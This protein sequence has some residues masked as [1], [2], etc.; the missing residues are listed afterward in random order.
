M[1][2]FGVT[3]DLARKKL[4]P[5][6]YDLANRGLLPPGFSLVGFARRDWEHEDFAQITYEAVKEH[7][8]TPFRETVWQQLQE[9]VRF[10][11]GEF[12]DDAAFDQ[13][14]R[15]RPPAG[16]R[17]RHRRQLRVLP[18]HTAEVL[19]HRG[20]AAQA[21]RAV[22]PGPGRRRR[23]HAVAP[24]GDREAV[25]PR[26][27]DGARS[28]TPSSTRCS[29]P[30]RCSASTTTWAR[31]PS[32]TSWRCASP[33]PC[34]SRSGTASYVDHVQI[35]MSEDIGI[36]GRAGY[37]DGIGAARDV[38][39]NHLLQL[40]ALT[41]MEEP[42]SFDADSLR[43]EKE[44]IL[45]AVRLPADLALG[46][47][48]GQYSA[49]WQGGRQV[50]RLPGGGRHPRRLAD[51]DLRR[52]AA[53]RR[54]QALGGRPVL[55]AH[56]QAAHPADDGDRADLPAGAAP[57]VRRHR[58]QGT[59]QERPGHPRPAGRG[60]HRAVRLQGARLGDGGPRREHGL[61]LRRVV[62]R[63]LARGLRAA[64]PRRA[65]RRPAAVPA[66]GGG[67]A[68]LAHPRPD[69]AV[70]GREHQAGAVRVGLGPG[71]RPPTR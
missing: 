48:R 37:Y 43:Q 28:S 1:V 5:A 50:A 15:D 71:P 19:P 40:L 27:G 51:R 24:G 29:P 55:P 60:R 21:V 7:A 31:R 47:A 46:T 10:V 18:V 23:A 39:Q 36:G 42:V 38:I 3:G 67:R 52:R 58:H 66:P 44:K 69:R 32:R 41:A 33:T 63:V 65:D 2:M 54:H 57:A 6:L 61:R 70:L 53:V 11:P 16:P 9:G 20:G 17:A 56:R 13:L 8:R 34:T 30:S 4:M 49:G 14:A 22:R 12:T 68:L 64:H 25:R 26:P 35:T 59:R 62:H 45:S